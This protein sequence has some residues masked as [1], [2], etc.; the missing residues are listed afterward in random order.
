MEP[1]DPFWVHPQDMAPVN[2]GL[3]NSW[4]IPGYFHERY[5]SDSI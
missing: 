2:G 5:V 4:Q 1:D 3:T